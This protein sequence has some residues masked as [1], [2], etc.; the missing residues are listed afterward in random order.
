MKASKKRK[1]IL[2]SIIISGLAFVFPFLIRSPADNLFSV[3]SLSF[4]AVGTIAT[5]A[6][7]VIAIFLYDRFGLES[8]FIEKQTDKVL[9]LAD[10]L[11]GKTINAQTRGLTYL[12]RPSKLQLNSFN[13]LEE[14]K[15]D[16]KKTIL[17]SVEDYE[18]SMNGIIAINRS[19]W[20]PSEIKEK[21]KFLII[22]GFMHL[23]SEVDENFVRF[24]F[25]TISDKDW[26]LPFP[27]MTFEN[28]NTNLHN[29]VQEIE[30]WLE[31]HSDI[32]ID[33]KLEEH[34]QNF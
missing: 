17:M 33:L 26:K 31:K 16:C 13:S 27:K 30:S 12:I 24:D 6:T 8:K 9:E 21:M 7:L 29:L 14:Y 18:L 20:L 19:Y 32:R 34:N 5:L 10:L 2:I 23:D 11:K 25:R 1:F 28:F 15:L 3:L 22:G 4:T